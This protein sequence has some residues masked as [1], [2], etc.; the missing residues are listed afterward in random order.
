VLLVPLLLLALSIAVLHDWRPARGRRPDP[1][2]AL[3]RGDVRGWSGALEVAGGRLQATLTRLH[4]DAARQAFEVE[5]LRRA[6]A[7]SEGE[8]WRLSLRLVG[9][10]A[11]GALDSA[12]ALDLSGL[13]VS[14]AQ[15]VALRPI[16]GGVA[17]GPAVAKP[18]EVLLAPPAELRGGEAC[19]LVLWG[20]APS[21]D[22]RI[23]GLGP[24]TL[25]LAA[26]SVRRRAEDEALARLD[27]IV[28]E[29]LAEEGRG[30]E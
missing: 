9:G 10:P 1:P 22:V 15:G 2:P 28:V 23:D 6:L 29:S 13:S 7:L 4:A 20:R 3:E 16:G 5:S 30:D 12:G 27:V 26:G 19:G 21:A 8:P 11:G 17:R 25:E 14:D 18:L 24:S